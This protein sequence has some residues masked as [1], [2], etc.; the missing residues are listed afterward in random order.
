MP[1]I[2]Q[3]IVVRKDLNMPAGKAF[4]QVAHASMKF[5]ADKIRENAAEDMVPATVTLELDE[6]QRAW[7]SGQFTKIALAV[8]SE[9]ELRELY[10]RCLEK[11]VTAALIVDNGTTVFNGVPT[12]TCLGIGPAPADVID[13]I[14]GHLKL[15]R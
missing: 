11:G 12:P 13:A 3:I 5:L 15:Y 1:P 9:E 6:A 4:S 14:T 2:K 7:F 10:D 8:H